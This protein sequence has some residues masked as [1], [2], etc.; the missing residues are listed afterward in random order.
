MT[1]VGQAPIAEGY[2][3]NT[4]ANQFVM[5]PGEVGIP[6]GF[7][8]LIRKGSQIGA[9]RFTSAQSNPVPGTGTA[10]YESYF[11]ADASGSFRSTAIRKQS[12][13][14]DLKPLK[15][16]GRLAF[17]TGKDLIKVGDWSFRSTAPG[18]INMWP[19]RGSQKDYGFEFAPTSARQVGEIDASDK[20]LR[21]FRFDPNARVNLPVSDLLR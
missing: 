21:W 8:L 19:Y 9:V 3:A 12:G 1:A 16:I 4:Q 2:V 20:R 17:Q 5:G 6:T 7:Y 15:G 11:P 18:T 14:I 13:E 10:N